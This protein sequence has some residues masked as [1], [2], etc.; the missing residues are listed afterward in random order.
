MNGLV[1]IGWNGMEILFEKK[2][3]ILPYKVVLFLSM[4]CH[5]LNTNY[6]KSQ[7]FKLS[8]SLKRQETSQSLALL[9]A[10]TLPFQKNLQQETR[11]YHLKFSSKGLSPG[12]PIRVPYRNALGISGKVRAS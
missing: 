2:K 10:K 5:W 4:K 9:L 7:V 11:N 3:N 1:D 6:K 12:N 8:F